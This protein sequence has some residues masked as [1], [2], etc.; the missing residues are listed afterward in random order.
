MFSIYHKILHVSSVERRLR[1]SDSNDVYFPS[2]H[3]TILVKIL[4]L[5]CLHFALYLPKAYIT[6]YLRRKKFDSFLLKASNNSGCFTLISEAYKIFYRKELEES[7]DVKLD[8]PS[9]FF[10]PNRKRISSTSTEHFP[11]VPIWTRYLHFYNI[12]QKPY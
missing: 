12:F 6:G 3:I 4:L 5:L 9:N 8:W 1:K 10:S 2:P 11:L 7:L